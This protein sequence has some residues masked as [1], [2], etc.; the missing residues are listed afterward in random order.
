MAYLYLVVLLR[1]SFEAPMRLFRLV[2]DLFLHQFNLCLT[3]VHK[4]PYPG[5]VR[6][7]DRAN[8]TEGLHFI[9]DEDVVQLMLVGGCSSSD[10]KSR[11]KFK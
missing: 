9:R 2:D 4:R 3:D 7:W 10:L 11:P 6:A 8:G 5:V 1:S